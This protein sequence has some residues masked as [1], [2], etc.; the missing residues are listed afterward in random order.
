MGRVDLQSDMTC[1]SSA[2]TINMYVIWMM[3][4][5]WSEGGQQLVDLANALE[6]TKQMQIKCI[7]Y[8]RIFAEIHQTYNYSMFGSNYSTTG[9]YAPNNSHLYIYWHSNSIMLK[10]KLIGR[11]NISA[12]FIAIHVEHD[13][14]R[15]LE[16]IFFKPF[17]LVWLSA[18][19]WT[20]E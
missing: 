6:K 13:L 1:V 11:F 19:C 17:A 16:I 18:G 20:K 4:W 15:V 3:Y 10:H 2:R 7:C 8:T 12:R 9:S 5:T 14:L